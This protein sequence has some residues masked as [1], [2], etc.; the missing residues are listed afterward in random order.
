MRQDKN[1]SFDRAKQDWIGLMIFKNFANRTGS[2]SILL[3]QDWT[4]TKKFHSPLKSVSHHKRQQR[5]YVTNQL[6]DN[7][8]VLSGILI[9]KYYF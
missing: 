9:E 4:R 5:I 3:D 2:D 1:S 8:Y 6:M 7:F